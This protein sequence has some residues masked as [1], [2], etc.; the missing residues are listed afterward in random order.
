V[1]RLELRAAAGDDVLFLH[2]LWRD[3]LRHAEAEEQV[4][5]V[6]ALVAA[7]AADAA[8]RLLIAEYDGEPAGAVLLRLA[9]YSP[10]NP[11]PTLQVFLPTVAP[12]HRRKG[13]GHALMEAAVAFAEELGVGHLASPADPASR[14]ANRF[15]ARLA[16]G[17]QATWRIAATASV[18]AKLTARRPAPQRVQ[19]RSQ[20]GQVLAARRSMRR[21]RAQQA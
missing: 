15:L 19:A 9:A 14:D 7:A 3:A 10:V 17:P 16:F 8:Q 1:S 21:A 5:D 18:R 11:E 6:A 20:L 12:T 13:L 2:G 4:D